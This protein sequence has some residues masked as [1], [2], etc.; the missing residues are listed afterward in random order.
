MMALRLEVTA[1]LGKLTVANIRGQ[2]SLFLNF[3]FVKG[4]PQS[5][6]A[7]PKDDTVSE[8]RCYKDGSDG[9]M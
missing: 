8:H 5:G 3:T 9:R 6:E 1:T 4:N 2:Q 7:R